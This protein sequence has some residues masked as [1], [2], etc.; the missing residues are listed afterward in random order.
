MIDVGERG[1]RG[2]ME[3]CGSR[4]GNGGLQPLELSA[5]APIGTLLPL[6]GN[7]IGAH[8]SKRKEMTLGWWVEGTSTRVSGATTGCGINIFFI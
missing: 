5:F 1:A 4:I 6:L 8:S 3:A 2:E 7:L